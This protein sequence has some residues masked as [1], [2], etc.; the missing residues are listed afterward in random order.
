M[1]AGMSAPIL[2]AVRVVPC[3][4]DVGDRVLMSKPLDKP[5]GLSYL[6]RKVRF[7]G[8]A[9]CKPQI[10][11]RKSTR[12]RAQQIA[13]QS[14][15]SEHSQKEVPGATRDRLRLNAGAT[16]QFRTR[17]RLN[18]SLQSRSAGLAGARDSRANRD[19]RPD[20]IGRRRGRRHVMVFRKPTPHTGVTCRR[21]GARIVA[22]D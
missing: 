18:A 21:S 12:G 15:R 9:A 20:W 19:H 17:I 8:H 2:L 1:S 11:V 13:L 14:C 7:R 4:A 3:D 16:G 6:T 5:G 22:P 10:A